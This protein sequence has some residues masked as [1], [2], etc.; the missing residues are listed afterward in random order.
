MAELCW[1]LVRQPNLLI[2][3][4]EFDPGPGSRPGVNHQDNRP[5]VMPGTHLAGSW[6]IG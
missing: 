3:D 4:V 1:N 6:D 2:A 5:T